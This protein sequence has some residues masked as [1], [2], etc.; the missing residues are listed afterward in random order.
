MADTKKIMSIITTKVDRLPD[1]PIKDAQLV[2]V[3]D[4]K[5]IAFD[6]KGKRTFYNQVIII[7]TDAERKGLLSPIVGGYYFVI[8]TAILWFYDENGWVQKTTP[9]ESY[10]FI[11]TELPE[12]GSANKLYVNKAEK[13]ISVWDEDT[14]T[15][16]TVANAIEEIGEEDI[17]SLFV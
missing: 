1:L 8:D 4:R 12:L 16:I 7:E 17:D 9:P 11:G 15:Y 3:Q 14:S 13:Y 6:W 2:F 10:L 5:L